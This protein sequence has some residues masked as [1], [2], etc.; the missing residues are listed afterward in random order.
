MAILRDI[1]EDIYIEWNWT[2]SKIINRSSSGIRIGGIADILG[3]KSFV[4]DH[5]RATGGILMYRN[6]IFNITP[7]IRT[8]R[9]RLV[10]WNHSLSYFSVAIIRSLAFK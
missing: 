2:G 6:Y 4:V 1:S 8:P 9:I 10:C 7:S 5:I 3:Y